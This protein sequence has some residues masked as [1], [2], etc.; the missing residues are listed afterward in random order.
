MT[1]TI[2][3]TTRPVFNLG[4]DLLPQLEDLVG[5]SKLQAIAT[6]AYSFLDNLLSLPAQE[7]ASAVSK[8]GL[9][10]VTS[11]DIHN[12]SS[13]ANALMAASLLESAKASHMTVHEKIQRT[14]RMLSYRYQAD[15]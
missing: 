6:Q 7:Q 8:L 11:M 12:D 2:A 3:T 9:S 5:S 13:I 14:L 1:T 15:W 10:A 4:N